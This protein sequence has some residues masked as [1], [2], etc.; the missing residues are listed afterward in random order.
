MRAAFAM[1]LM[2]LGACNR[3]PDF[4]QRYDEASKQIG[5]AAQEIDAELEQRASGAAQ[6]V[7]PVQPSS[8][9]GQQRGSPSSPVP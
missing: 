3:E 7:N 9:P 2:L 1:G 4:S 8:A 6:P 5:T